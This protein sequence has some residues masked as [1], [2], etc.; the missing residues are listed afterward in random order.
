MPGANFQALIASVASSGTTYRY[1]RVVITNT[2]GGTYAGFRELDFSADGGSTWLPSSSMTSNSAPSPLVASASSE[3]SSSFAAWYAFNG[4]TADDWSTAAS[5]SANAWI[6]LDLGSGNGINPNA[7]RYTIYNS[8][9]NNYSPTE[10]KLYGS[11]TGSFSGE[12]T[13][14]VTKSALSSQAHNTTVTH[15]W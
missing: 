7:M 1:L 11:D 2:H 13:L 8:A 15:T 4:N 10:V 3:F 5:A 9:G 12:Q 6:T 14:L